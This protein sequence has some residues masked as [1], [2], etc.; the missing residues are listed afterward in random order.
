MVEQHVI[1]LAATYELTDANPTVST[2][3]RSVRRS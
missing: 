2:R 1:D 3:G